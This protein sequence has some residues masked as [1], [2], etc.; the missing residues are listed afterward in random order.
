[1][2]R[3]LTK[4]HDFS[5]KKGQKGGVLYPLQGVSQWVMHGVPSYPL[6]GV[7]LGVMHDLFQTSNKRV[8]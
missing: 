8:F 6:Q 1:M 5:A 3:Y 4:I 7:P 2:Q